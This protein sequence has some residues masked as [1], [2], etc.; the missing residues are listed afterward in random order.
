MRNAFAL[1]YL[2]LGNYSLFHRV[3][4]VTS[5]R[6]ST[7]DEAIFNPNSLQL[8][9]SAQLDNRIFFAFRDHI[10]WPASWIFHVT[11]CN[12]SCSAVRELLW[13]SFTS[14]V[15]IS[16]FWILF[17]RIAWTSTIFFSH[18]V[19]NFNFTHLFQGTI[20]FHLIS[21]DTKFIETY[22]WKHPILN[23]LSLKPRYYW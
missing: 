14:V 15:C 16:T 18:Q 5:I 19:S 8:F 23:K 17:V 9:C 11:I 21:L 22:F 7:V 10:H 20:Y 1:E 3:Y 4:S 2:Y 6:A 12:C 13:P